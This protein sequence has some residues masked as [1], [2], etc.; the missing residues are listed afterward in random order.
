MTRK[1]YFQGNNRVIAET[2]FEMLERMTEAVNKFLGTDGA[3][4][5][6]KMKGKG[7]RRAHEVHTSVVASEYG[8][9]C[10]L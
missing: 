6:A 8:C 2:P 1:G 10:M 5:G 7:G 4:A 3:G 9:K